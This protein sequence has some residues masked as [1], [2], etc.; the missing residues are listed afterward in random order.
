[1][2]QEKEKNEAMTNE[3]SAWERR[4]YEARCKAEG[5]VYDP[6]YNFSAWERRVPL[7]DGNYWKGHADYPD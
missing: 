6:E 2:I 4:V 1:M 5:K 7:G 3:M